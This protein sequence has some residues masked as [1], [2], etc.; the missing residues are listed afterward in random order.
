MR[1]CGGDVEFLMDGEILTGVYLP[2]D[3]CAEHEWGIKGLHE[4]FGI[5]NDVNVI[6]VDRYKANAVPI[7]NERRYSS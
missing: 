3:Y 6:G 5:L 4:S 2:A 7:S 1:L